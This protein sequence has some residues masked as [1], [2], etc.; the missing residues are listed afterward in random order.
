MDIKKS[1]LYKVGEKWYAKRIGA[2]GVIKIQLTDVTNGTVQFFETHRSK[3]NERVE[4]CDIK[5][6]EMVS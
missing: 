1:D 3:R 5:L 2:T 6:I 4:Y